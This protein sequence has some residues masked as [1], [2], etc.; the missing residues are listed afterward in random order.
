VS[1]TEAVRSAQLLMDDQEL[2]L[3]MSAPVSIRDLSPTRSATGCAMRR[4]RASTPSPTLYW[5][6]R[7]QGRIQEGNALCCWLRRGPSERDPC[8][9]W[10]D[11]HPNMS[12]D[13]LVHI[14]AH[15]PN[16][17]G[18]AVWRSAAP[19]RT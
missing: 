9:R 2:A 13:L 11:N 6:S 7:Q 14:L 19:S 16:L 8:P 4:C 10:G 3:L 1:F 15:L 17:E 5:R 12:T 18:P